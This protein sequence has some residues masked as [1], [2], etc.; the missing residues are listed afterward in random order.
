[1]CSAEDMQ[2]FFFK[3]YVYV[4]AT[5]WVMTDLYRL[6]YVCTI[7][8]LVWLLNAFYFSIPAWVSPAV[9]AFYPS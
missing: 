9:N 8:A 4:N 3:F 1:M 2:F 5:L 7:N 6:Y